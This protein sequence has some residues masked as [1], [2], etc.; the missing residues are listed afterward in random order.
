MLAKKFSWIPKLPV[1]SGENVIR[2]LSNQGFTVSKGRRGNVVLQCNDN[3]RKVI[4]PLHLELK[5]GTLRAI[6][7]QACLTVEEYV[8]LL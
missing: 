1:V 8:S 6:I 2:V 4:V 5:S 7:R 3:Y